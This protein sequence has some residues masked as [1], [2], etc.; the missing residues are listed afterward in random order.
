MMTGFTEETTSFISGDVSLEGTLTLPGNWNQSVA[1][2]FVHGS[3]PVD[4]N[5]N[6][7]GQQLNVFNTLAHRLARDCIASLRYDKRGCAQSGGDYFASDLATFRNDI[8]AAIAHTR[9]NLNP[10]VLVLVGHSEGTLLSVQ[11][12]AIAPV[13][14]LVLIMPFVENGEELLL[15]QGK[16]LER[17]LKAMPGVQGVILRLASYLRGGIMAA[18]RRTIAKVKSDSSRTYP[19]GLHGLSVPAMRDFMIVDA[20]AHYKQINCPV[21]VLGGAKD[22]QCR[23]EDVDTIKDILG[24]KAEAHTLKDMTHIMRRDKNPP[25]LANYLKLQHRPLDAEFGDR[26]GDWIARTLAPVTGLMK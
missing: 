13:E 12:S 17:A 18:Q 15:R 23:P 4:R 3:G 10:Q 9:Q 2:I 7:R 26:I 22:L 6:L 8:V 24:T 25:N 20:L 5:E 1:V 21:L 14:G 19:K 11:A 16:E